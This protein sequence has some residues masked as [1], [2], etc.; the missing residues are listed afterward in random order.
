MRE[1]N[2]RNKDFN[3]NNKKNRLTMKLSSKSK[4]PRI[5]RLIF[6]MKELIDNY[7]K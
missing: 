6:L 2:V 4:K 3:K 1:K 5:L 7:K